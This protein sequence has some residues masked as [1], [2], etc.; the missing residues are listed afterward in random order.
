MVACITASVLCVLFIHFSVSVVGVPRAPALHL[1]CKDS[2]Q[3]ENDSLSSNYSHSQIYE[4]IRVK[5]GKLKAKG[6]SPSCPCAFDVTGRC[7]QAAHMCTASNNT[8]FCS[9]SMKKVII[10]AEGALIDIST[11][12]MISLAHPSVAGGVEPK[13]NPDI[14]TSW[15]EGYE[16][17]YKSFKSPE[18]ASLPVH[19]DVVPVR[20]RW[21][22]CFNHLSFQTMPFIAS[23]IELYPTQWRAFTWHASI[24]SA[25]LLR[26]LDVPLN[27]I[28]IAKTI[29]AK[30]V[31]LPWIR[32]WNPL[33][34][35]SI[36]GIA[37]Q[38]SELTTT[39]LLA[40]NF[41]SKELQTL[42]PLRTT[43]SE[44]VLKGRKRLV[45]YLNRTKQELYKPRGVVNEDEILRVIKESLSRDLELVVLGHTVEYASIDLLHMSWQR[46]ARII[47]RARVII[48]PHGG[49]CVLSSC[50]FVRVLSPT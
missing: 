23:V 27:Q 18:I 50:V 39:K 33:Q 43:L 35:S 47:S 9:F 31:V 41:S 28:V 49:R 16:I 10:S 8:F 38:F 17:A 32:S 44:K 29:V 6:F 46:Y 13:Y 1:I 12:K 22:D 45:V 14:F 21:D 24:F 37:K 48:G 20:M 11:M 4:N 19:K 40:M 3:T 7:R 25:A 42:E 30:R 2:F 36:H 34:L 5:V 15:L 26:L